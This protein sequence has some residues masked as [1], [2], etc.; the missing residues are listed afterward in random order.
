MSETVSDLIMHAMSEKPID[1]ENTFSSLI[2]NKIEF[3]IATRKQEVAQSM[4]APAEQPESP[5]E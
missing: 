1:F 5:E 4:F 2:N 3:A